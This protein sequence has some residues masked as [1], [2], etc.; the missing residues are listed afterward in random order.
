MKKAI[1][2]VIKPVSASALTT[3]AGLL[4]LLFMTFTIGFDIGIV[5][6]KGIV[7][8][9]VTSL[10]LL[11][12]LVLMLDKPLEKTRKRAFV[13][14]G[15]TFCNVSFKAGKAIVPIALVLIIVCGALQPMSKYTFSDS[16]APAE[17]I[18]RTFG[19]NN[20]VVVVY[21]SSENDD[22]NE[23]L[24]AQ[25]L[26][27][28]K[29]SDSTNALINYTAYSNTAKEAY[30]VEKARQKL[31]I[32]ES[33]AELLLTMCNLYRAPESLRLTFAEFVDYA[34]ELIECDPDAKE[35][36]DEQTT[37]TVRSLKSI[38]LVTS[39]DNTAEQYASRLSGGADGVSV[40]LFTVKQAYGLYFYDRVEN[41]DVE[42]ATMVNFIVA[43]SENENVSD[44]F[45]E[46]TVSQLR[47]LS[48]VIANI[49][50]ENPLY[51][52][53]H[54]AYGYKQ[55]LPV[56]KQV[57]TALTGAEPQISVTDDEIQQMYIMYFYRTGAMPEDA[58]N[59]KTFTAF[60]LGL[61]D[62]NAVV[63]ARLSETDEKLL[64][65]VLTVDAFLSDTGEY[66]FS[67]LHG[68]FTAL[69]SAVQSGV[70]SIAPEKD[71]IAGVYIKYSVA[72]GKSLAL[73]V[74]ALEL[75]D[76]VSGNME[77]NTLL[78]QKLTPDMRVKVDEAQRDLQKAEELFIGNEYSRLLLS[79]DL[80]NE[81]EET[82]EFVEYLNATV[83]E[84]FGEEAYVAGE[85]ISTYD[86]QESFKRDNLLISVFTIVAIF[87]IVAV[88]FRSLSLPV[89]LVAVIQGAIWISMALRLFSGGT[90]FMS[91][92]VATCI[93]MG[94]TIDY[95]I[96]MSSNYV[97]NR[98][99][100]DKKAAL[101]KCVETAMP[102][103]FSSGLILI[104][105]GFVVHFI[106]SQNAISTVGLLIGTG[107]VFSVL[108]ITLVLPSIL[109]LFDKFV[110]KLSL[111][112]KNKN[113]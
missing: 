1:K 109:W 38:G 42:F 99:S 12:A 5:L 24:L 2:S 105:C 43:A 72:H 59:G 98:R 113:P 86:L 83:K 57:V 90:F 92:I 54:G 69:Q 51:P 30:D 104:V 39:S 45:D 93:L 37:Q 68:G 65:D 110:L 97:D 7:I 48:A 58:I 44:M 64:K 13:P 11:P 67:E 63:K 84:I 77:T 23:R 55:F 106:S 80:P 16:A 95:G 35:F 17:E 33:D 60:V 49:P 52:V 53:V 87:I 81:G 29:K 100:L 91:Y 107:A 76:F 73:P 26:A 112:K 32:S 15:K 78:K 71:K 10:T 74:T 89:I 8:S 36:A 75:L 47:L 85:I 94:A 50:E 70:S 101:Y 6:M 79:V 20:A 46:Q 66:T 18:Q 34:C 3:V 88:I 56:L 82:T 21:K 28:Y 4:A 61:Y 96:L 19:Q 9:V 31:D 41:P 40:D 22:E 103:V 111:K 62:T 25:K 14:R 27:E 102:T 108:M